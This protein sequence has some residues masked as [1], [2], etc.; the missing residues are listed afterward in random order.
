MKELVADP[1]VG[2]ALIDA[3]K[4]EFPDVLLTHLADWKDGVHLND[5]DDVL[6]D[7]LHQE[8]CVLVS[9]DKR[10]LAKHARE[11]IQSGK[12]HPGIILFRN[13]LKDASYGKQAKTLMDFWRKEHA[14]D[15]TDRI[16][17]LPLD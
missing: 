17:Y 15:W 12:S 13:S 1:H 9:Y 10:S 6:L 5:K 7:A 11:A 3:G 2:H 16:V 14:A 4:K 8:G